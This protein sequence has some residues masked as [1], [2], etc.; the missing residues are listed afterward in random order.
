MSQPS[1]FRTPRQNAIGLGP[2]REGVAH[3][4]ASR[5]TSIALVPLGIAFIFPFVRALGDSHAAVLAL[6]QQPW[7]AIVAILFIG[8]TFSHIQQGLQ[9]VVEDYVHNKPVRTVALLSNIG[10]SWVF[11]LIGVFAHGCLRVHRPHT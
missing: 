7:H 4:W 5:L 1:G 3:W 8:V 10:L 6:Y 9:V 11:G 2:A